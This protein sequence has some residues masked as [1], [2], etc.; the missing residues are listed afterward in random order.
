MSISILN[1]SS[2]LNSARQLNKSQKY[3]GKSFEKLSSGLRI[4]RAA[5]DAAGLKIA[6][7]FNSQISGL[8]QA[9]RNSN[10]GISLVQTAE[11]A[12]N[13]TTSILQRMRELAVQ[14]ANGTFSDS[15]RESIQDETS[16]LIQ[17]IDRVALETSFNGRKILD[18][19][20]NN[21]K[22]QVGENAGQ[23]ID[24]SVRGATSK[25]FGQI[26]QSTGNSAV[27][28]NALAEGELEINGKLVR[29]SSSFVGSAAGQDATSAFAKAQAINAS[30]TGVRAEAQATEFEVAA[31][32]IAV[33]ADETL[34]ING[35]AIFDNNQ[36]SNITNAEELAE[37][38]NAFSADTGVTAT[39]DVTND[40]FTLT[41]ADG[42]NIDVVNNGTTTAFGTATTRGEIQLSSVDDIALAGNVASIGFTGVAGISRDNN[43]VSDLDLSTQ[44]GAT[45]A[46]ERIDAALDSVGKSRGELGALQNRFEST[47][48][49]LSNV[50]ENLN[51]ARSRLLDTDFAQESINLTKNQLLQQAGT[52]ILAQSKQSSQI[53]L[54]LLG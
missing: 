8:G 51:A 37:A 7:R 10:D 52:T 44:G 24:I 16:Q 5:D 19:S 35:V 13:E 38:I 42:R 23:T 18:G 26:A 15:D 29:G 36:G 6:E 28:G 48:S 14:S 3:L 9:I 43:S 4:N 46:I 27:D 53:A 54:N 21:L 34:E 20:A 22:F 32:G 1:N 41:A 30:G 47:I 11:G 17:E 50:N 31:S 2:A 45:E 40:T 49:N 12:L 25:S 39:V 33:A